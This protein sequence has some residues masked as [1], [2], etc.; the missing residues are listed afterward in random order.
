[1]SALLRLASAALACAF[2]AGC[3]TLAQTPQVD[4]PPT[5]APALAPQAPA[6]AVSRAPTGSL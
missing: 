6:A 4:M 3:S 5:V 2:V 1:M